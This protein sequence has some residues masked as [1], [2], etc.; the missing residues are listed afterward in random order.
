MVAFARLS[1]TDGSVVSDLSPRDSVPQQC[2]TMDVDVAVDS[3]GFPIVFAQYALSDRETIYYDSHGSEGGGSTLPAASKVVTPPPKRPREI[4]QPMD[5]PLDPNST[6]RKK[7][8]K[9]SRLIFVLCIVDIQS[10]VCF[11]RRY[12]VRP[13]KNV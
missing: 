4:R 6:R 13:P 9:A 5:T 7:L 12:L 3:E 2:N 10:K 1:L 8:I 11:G